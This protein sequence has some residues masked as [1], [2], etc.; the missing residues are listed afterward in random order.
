MRSLRSLRRRIAAR[1]DDRGIATVEM[2]IIA[3]LL[4]LLFGGIIEFGF[5]WRDDLTA[6]ASTRASARV[7]SNLG[8]N[9]L[10]D[11]EALL[12]LDAGLSG[13]D[14]L[15]VEGVLIYDASALDGDPHASCFDG[16]GNPQTSVG[17]CNYYTAV[18]LDAVSGLSC[19]PSCAEF[20]DDPSCASGWAQ[21][22]CPQSR[23]TNQ[24]TG[25]SIVGVWVRM[26]RDFVTG[27]FPG[28]GVTITDQTVMRVEPG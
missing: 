9:H 6:S 7:V 3:P 1:R 4:A 20:P 28:D 12:A 24:G 15:V 26:K 23:S 11:Y 2:A 19:S 13:V 21:A 14:N 18:Q 16:S 5:L 22:F 10:A 25:T 27:L 8:D 17:H